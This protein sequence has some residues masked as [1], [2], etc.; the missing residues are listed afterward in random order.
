MSGNVI[1]RGPVTSGHQPRT[2][3]D[4]TVAGA[5][6][7]GTFVEA[8]ADTL[9]QLTTALAKL[10]MILSNVD[11]KDQDIATAYASGDTGV[12]YHLEPG[13]IYQARLAAATYAK[14]APLTIGAAGRLTAATAAT[15][16]IAFFD[17]T[18]GAYSAGGLAD[19]IIAN[20]YTV[21]AV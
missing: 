21:P 8:A 5:Y 10:P 20:T 16:V 2:I 11:F 1:Y 13:Q 12:A 3:S 18:P 15:P 7:P 6:L 17:D 14:G 9:V 19:V 4:K